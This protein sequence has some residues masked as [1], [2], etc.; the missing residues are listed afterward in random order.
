MFQRTAAKRKPPKSGGWTARIGNGGPGGPIGT[1]GNVVGTDPVYLD[2]RQGSFEP[3]D[4]YGDLT[5][6][7]RPDADQW[8]GY[9]PHYAEHHVD[10]R[11]GSN[12]ATTSWQKSS[13]LDQTVGGHPGATNRLPFTL[14]VVDTNTV[15]DFA[16]RGKQVKLRRQP[17]NQWGP[18]VGGR[19][20]GSDFAAGV[21]QEAISDVPDWIAQSGITESY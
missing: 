16:L 4:P 7:N 13:D 21:G 8:P 15:E 12:I 3:I 17:E 11:N 1:P 9:F 5:R 14:G 10:E 18:V 2:Q 20:G 6:Q 19:S